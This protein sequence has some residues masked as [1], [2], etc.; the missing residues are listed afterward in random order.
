MLDTLWGIRTLFQAAVW[1]TDSEISNIIFFTYCKPDNL[2]R[3]IYS[4]HSTNLERCSKTPTASP[5][6]LFRLRLDVIEQGDGLGLGHMIN[7]HAVNIVKS[8]FHLLMK[9]ITCP[10][11]FIGKKSI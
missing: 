2:K 4:K 10:Q 5:R 11:A 9:T 3:F 7:L 1:H 6:N 8:L